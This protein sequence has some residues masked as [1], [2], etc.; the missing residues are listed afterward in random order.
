[1]ERYA[2]IL[3][4]GK[5]ERFWPLSTPERPKPFLGLLEGKSLLQATG[6]RLLPIFGASRT[7]VV[8]PPHLAPLAREQLPWLPP[9]N[10]LEEPEP[11][12]TAFA[13]AFA[14]K[15]LPEGTVAFFPADHF[16]GDEGAFREDV[17]LALGEAERLRGILT[18]GVPPTYPATGYGYLEQGDCS[19]LWLLHRRAPLRLHRH[20]ERFP[21]AGA[22]PAG[23][24]H[25]GA[26]TEPPHL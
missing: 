20:G 1:M 24:A 4:G 21:G 11:K 6:D 16:V 15:R 22:G 3:A 8:V 5:G 12:D 9:E 19:D 25:P 17:A 14:L 13:V 18:L 7:Y 2:V 26:G 23:A 10:L